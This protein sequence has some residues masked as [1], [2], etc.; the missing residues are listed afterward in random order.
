MIK[1]IITYLLIIHMI[2][3]SSCDDDDNNYKTPV[4][5]EEME[6]LIDSYAYFNGDK[7]SF[8]AT[9]KKDADGNRPFNV[10]T[11]DWTFETWVKVEKGT[12]ISDKVLES[13]IVMEQRYVFTL[14]ISPANPDKPQA[15]REIK[16]IDYSQPNGMGT[17]IVKVKADY[18]ITYSKLSNTSSDLELQSMSTFNNNDIVLLYGD[19]VHVAITRSSE[20]NTARFFINGKQVT[21]ST[22][23]VW[24]SKSSIGGVNWSATYRGAYYGFTKCEQRKTR[25]STIARYSADFN[26]DLYKDFEEDKNT[27]FLLNLKKEEMI[28]AKNKTP[29]MLVKGTY[30]H[31]VSLRQNNWQS[32]RKMIYQ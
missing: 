22:D 26:P 19:W 17:K 10:L 4:I 32:D 29:K 18:E 1:K 23:D 25:I 6:T 30:P 15:D 12:T 9:N 11:T 16:V 21:S 5:T 3:L 14:Y 20:D 27:L 28:D 13:S 24:I 2:I 8:Y 31:S 7:Q